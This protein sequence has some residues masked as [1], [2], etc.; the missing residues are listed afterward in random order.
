MLKLISP[1]MP[2]VTDE[3]FGMLPFKDAE[4]IMISEYP[5]YDEDMIY[6]E[7]K[8]NHI[9]E[10]I[11]EFRTYKLENGI[12]KE[13][14]VRLNN[15]SNYD[16]ILKMLKLTDRIS[17]DTDYNNCYDVIYKDFSITVYYPE[18]V[19]ENDKLLLEKQINDL[20]MSIERRKKLLYIRKWLVFKSF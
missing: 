17:D 8:M 14:S 5:K 13:F 7:T 9:I 10:F 2:Y 19:N 11:K 12:G 20:K 18:I 15:T 1:F 16:L 3:I 4:S 6:P